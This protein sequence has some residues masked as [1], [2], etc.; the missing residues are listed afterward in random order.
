MNVP[1]WRKGHVVEDIEE[2]EQ[3]GK[4]EMM[5]ETIENEENNDE[6]NRKTTRNK[7]TKVEIEFEQLLEEIKQIESDLSN[8]NKEYRDKRILTIEVIGKDTFEEKCPD[9]DDE[10]EKYTNAKGK[11]IKSLA[12]LGV[13]IK[14]MKQELDLKHKQFESSQQLMIEMNATGAQLI[15]ELKVIQQDHEQF[16]IDKKELN[17]KI[18]NLNHECTQTNDKIASIQVVDELKIK[19][20]QYEKGLNLLFI[21][22]YV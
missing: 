15:K 5:D 7:K 20:A 19:V 8:N 11:Q 9:I 21:N 4:K 1:K 22:I 6:T 3:K 14:T 10:P 17:I 18:D 13:K 2:D 16:M 12:E